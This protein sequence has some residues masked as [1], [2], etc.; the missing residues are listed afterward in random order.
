M[1]EEYGGQS[2]CKEKGK[3]RKAMS[4]KEIGDTQD[5][6]VLG[7]AKGGERSRRMEWPTLPTGTARSKEIRTCGQGSVGCD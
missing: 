5:T 2:L 1:R 3:K 4:T 6:A 7:K